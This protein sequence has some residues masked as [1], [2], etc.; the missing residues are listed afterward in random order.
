MGDLSRDLERSNRSGGR[1][2][3]GRSYLRAD[4]K[5]MD[6]GRLGRDLERSGRGGGR[7]R[8]GRPHLPTSQRDP[9]RAEEERLQAR[10]EYKQATKRL[11]EALRSA[12]VKSTTGSGAR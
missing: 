12:K 5:E 4:G 8:G 2:R 10:N 11:Y 9:S 7:D 1:D 3:G 6:H